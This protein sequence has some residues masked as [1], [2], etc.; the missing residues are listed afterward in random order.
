MFLEMRPQSEKKE[1][2]ISHEGPYSSESFPDENPTWE[3][4]ETNIDTDH[5][6]RYWFKQN[7]S[8]AHSRRV[9]QS[10]FH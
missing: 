4:L 2:S 3:I 8:E 6:R 10:T 5:L 9:L 1:S 7:F